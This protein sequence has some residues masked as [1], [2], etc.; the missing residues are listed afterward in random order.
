MTVRAPRMQ[1][2]RLEPERAWLKGGEGSCQLP[3]H[4][5]TNAAELTGLRS[6][7]AARR[8]K[9]NKRNIHSYSS[10]Q[11]SDVNPTQHLPGSET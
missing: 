5:Q 2:S 3:D 9:E 8:I 6:L 7:G 4:T 11:S 1:V 10:G